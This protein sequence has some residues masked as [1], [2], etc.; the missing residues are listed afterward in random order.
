MK[1]NEVKYIGSAVEVGKIPSGNIP[2]FAFMGR[3]NVGK[4]SLINMILGRKNLA[5]IS[6]TPGKTRTINIF[7][8]DSV[9]QLADL[10]GYGYAKVSKSERNKWEQLIFEY[11]KKRQNLVTA[12]IL[13]DLRI[14]PQ[15]SD[16][17]M[18][19]WMGKNRIPFSIL[20]AKS[21][22]LK[23]SQQITSVRKF[24]DRLQETWS[25]LPHFL[26]TSSKTEIGKIELL[27]IIEKILVG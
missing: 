27:D 18:I 2:E 22:K 11:L 17:K 8:V 4:S 21:D 26:V 13:V 12:F 15:D 10:P 16:I 23:T 3:S 5:R 7:L 6:A 14:P 20:F 9:W 1:I 24:L 19:N 25:T